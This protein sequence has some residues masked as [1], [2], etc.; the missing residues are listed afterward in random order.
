MIKLYKYFFNPSNYNVSEARQGSTQ[1]S[2]KGKI[3]T[4]YTSDA[5]KTFTITLDNLSE[6][7][8]YNLL[9]IISLV[10]PTDGGGQDLPFTDPLGNDYTV[11]IP[12]DGYSFNLKD[13]EENLWRWELTLE[14]VI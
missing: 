7:E 5:Y 4:D 2:R 1:R 13:T 3:F 14:E 9:F 8:H 12:I 10:F 6:K 11:T